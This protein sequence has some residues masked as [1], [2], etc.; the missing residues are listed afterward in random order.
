[1]IRKFILL[2]LILSCISWHS[3]HGLGQ[4]V[5]EKTEVLAALA[6]AGILS[7]YGAHKANTKLTELRKEL[8]QTD[9][10]N[11]AQ[12]KSSIWWCNC[13]RI[14]AILASTGCLTVA[15]AGSLNKAFGT[16]PTLESDP[17]EV[18][19]VKAGLIPPLASPQPEQ[20]NLNAK[21]PKHTLDPEDNPPPTGPEP[22]V[23]PPIPPKPEKPTLVIDFSDDIL[24]A[25]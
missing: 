7:G 6:I 19:P 3:S 17:L 9:S 20:P 1:M 14:A 24:G 10:N 12:L 22:A 16:A 21:N 18:D 23:K 13:L 8:T 15:C 5:P 2:S 11:Q 4:H 25:L